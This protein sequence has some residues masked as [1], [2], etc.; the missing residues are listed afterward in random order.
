[1]L[2]LRPIGGLCNRMLA[3]ASAIHLSKDANKSLKIIWERNPMLNA[4]FEYLFKPL[5]PDIT[6]IETTQYNQT[7]IKRA[8]RRLLDLK[9]NKVIHLTT[10]ATNKISPSF[11]MNQQKNLI[12]GGNRF[13]EL[14]DLSKIFIPKDAISQVIDTQKKNLG[15]SAI[16]LHIRRTDHGP[17]ISKSPTRLFVDHIKKEIEC[18]PNVLF[19][20]A[21]DEP[22]EEILIKTMFPNRIITYSKKTLNRNEKEGIKDALVDLMC[23]AHCVKI[24]GSYYSS[25]SFTAAQ[26]YDR[27]LVVLGEER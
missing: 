21:T 10:L 3:V 8:W 16:G 22:Q 6:I 9:Y 4:S 20:L 5:D 13:Y 17:S 24:Y 19:F 7:I 14:G 25:F 11:I 12:Y 18:D 27:K 1:M 2:A 23:L 15:A 26:F